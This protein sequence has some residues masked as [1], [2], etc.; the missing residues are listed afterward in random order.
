MERKTVK[1][2]SILGLVL[3]AASAVTAAMLPNKSNDKSV[4]AAN[5]SLTASSESP[6]L[7][8]EIQAGALGDDCYA[9]T[10]AGTNVAN[11]DLGTNLTTDDDASIT[12]EDTANGAP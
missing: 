8:C 11:T 10:A 7:T 1:Q 2:V 9:T 5:G 12:R 6:K 4:Q 3:L